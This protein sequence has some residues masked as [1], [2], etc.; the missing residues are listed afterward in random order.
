MNIRSIDS[1]CKVVVREIK[2]L[3]DMA[4][5]EELV[6]IPCARFFFS[7]K[8]EQDLK[9][10]WNRLQSYRSVNSSLKEVRANKW[11]KQSL[12]SMNRKRP[13]E[14]L[15]VSKPLPKAKP[16]L[17]A[18]QRYSDLLTNLRSMPEYSVATSNQSNKEFLER[19]I[20]SVFI[21]CLIFSLYY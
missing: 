8:T 9:K 6:D 11:M 1:R 10:S 20:L 16:M 4:E 3:E 14:Q 15:Q 12:S 17:S 21:A 7:T 18:E 13:S 2:E 19:F 5:V